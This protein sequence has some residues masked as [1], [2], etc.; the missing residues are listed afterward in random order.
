M[1][2]NS[3]RLQWLQSEIERDKQDVES[4][5][6]KFIEQIKKLKKE[7]IFPKKLSL[8]KRILRLFMG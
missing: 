8:W 6:R 2:T 1:K 5:K 7:E 4:E 3:S